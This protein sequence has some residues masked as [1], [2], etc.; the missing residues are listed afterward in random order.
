MCARFFAVAKIMTY[1]MKKLFTFLIF[2]FALFTNSINAEISQIKHNPWELIIYR[3][4]NSSNLNDIRC[5]LKIEDESGN[6][7]SKTKVKAKYE[8]ISNPGT[9]YNY[10]KSIFINGGM[11]VHLNLKKGRYRFS[12]YTPESELKYFS[13]SAKEV[14]TSNIFEYNTENPAKVIFIIPQSDN[15][16]FYS[17]KWIID[18]K[19][20]EWFKFTKPKI[21]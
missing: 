19:S 2:F 7:V 17:G 18:Y 20:P 11:A 15:N 5:W 8:W 10:K 6:E 3:P 21:K 14:W 9:F 13:G 4:E 12:V 16:G 1:Q